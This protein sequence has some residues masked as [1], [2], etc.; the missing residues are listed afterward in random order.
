M[1]V[2]TTASTGQADVATVFPW[3]HLRLDAY[4]AVQQRYETSQSHFAGKQQ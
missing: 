4:T 2:L 3:T 1:V